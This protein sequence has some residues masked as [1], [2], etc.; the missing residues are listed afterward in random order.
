MKGGREGRGGRTR[1]RTHQKKATS[2][3]ERHSAEKLKSK[4]EFEGRLQ[5]KRNPRARGKRERERSAPSRPSETAAA[6]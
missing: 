2:E 3:E 4:R 6:S 5:Q 1:H